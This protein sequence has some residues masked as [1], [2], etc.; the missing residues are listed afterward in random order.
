MDKHTDTYFQRLSDDMH[1]YRTLARRLIWFGV[2]AFLATAIA[3]GIILNTARS[4][5]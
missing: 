4:A 5:T 1:G 2:F 3:I